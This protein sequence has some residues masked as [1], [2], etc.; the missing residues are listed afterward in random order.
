MSPTASFDCTWRAVRTGM[1]SSQ[2]RRLCRGRHFALLSEDR[3]LLDIGPTSNRVQTAGLNDKRVEHL[4]SRIS[5]GRRRP[6]VSIR[7]SGKR[8]SRLTTSTDNDARVTDHLRP[9]DRALRRTFERR[10]HSGSQGNWAARIEALHCLRCI[11]STYIVFSRCM[12]MEAPP[13][14]IDCIP[15]LTCSAQAI[16][17]SVDIREF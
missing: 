1:L 5:N 16:L 6:T 11:G 3:A 10:L 7:F 12:G 4:Y 2:R 13:A 15:L 8:S 14:S 9:F 17:P